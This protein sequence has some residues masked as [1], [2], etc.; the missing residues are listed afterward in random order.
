MHSDAPL[1]SRGHDVIARL[2]WFALRHG[3]EDGAVIERMIG[4]LRA[5]AADLR[6]PAVVP[7]LA[8]LA[9]Y[10]CDVS[11]EPPAAVHRVLAAA[12]PIEARSPF[13]KLSDALRAEGRTEGRTQAFRENLLEQLAIRFGAVD[14]AVRK[15]VEEAG[16]DR[17]QGWLRRV[18]V[19]T[20][21]EAVFTS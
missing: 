11:D 9:R 20:T 17:L 13:M 4:A 5:L 2:N 10:V 21:V 1:L 19:A 14:D 3:R 6:G 15:R 12:V 16:C 18:V 7:A 8:R